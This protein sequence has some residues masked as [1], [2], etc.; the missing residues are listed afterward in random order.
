MAHHAKKGAKSNARIAFL[1]ES[2]ISE[3]PNVRRTWALK[4]KTPVIF[5][6]G[7]WKVRSVVGVI[8]CTPAGNDPRLYIRIFPG[9]VRKEEIVRFLKEL[10][11]H[12]RGSV[13]LVWDRLAAHR[14]RIVKEYIVQ[15]PWLS[16]EHFPSYAPELN[17][18]EYVWATAKNRDLANLYPDGLRDLDRH[19]RTMKKR[20]R[21]RADLLKGFLKKSSLFC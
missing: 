21:R 6:T 18:V 3:R 20:L 1:D 19:I 10:R 5:S 9:A 4:G 8:T 7:S 16:A 11:R 12:V 2:G 13:I 15:N 14:A 17:P